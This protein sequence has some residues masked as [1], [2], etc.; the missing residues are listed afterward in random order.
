MSWA[1]SSVSSV[2]ALRTFCS[3]VMFLVRPSITQNSHSFLSPAP[4]TEIIDGRTIGSCMIRGPSGSLEVNAASLTFA[5]VLGL[6]FVR[7]NLGRLPFTYSTSTLGE[8][9]SI[10]AVG[11]VVAVFASV[12]SM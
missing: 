5:A 8:L 11:A 10:P 7:S 1:T 2:P 12:L 4:T 9:L 6:S 3:E